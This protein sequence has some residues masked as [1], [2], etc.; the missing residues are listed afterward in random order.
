MMVR[1]WI[2]GSVGNIALAQPDARNAFDRDM[3]G[4][5][6]SAIGEVASNAGVRCLLI[7]GDGANFSVGGDLQSL[8]VSNSAGDRGA[9]QRRARCR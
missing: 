5:L 7:C 2:T 8:G 1:T 3:A 6:H 9:Q 4:Q